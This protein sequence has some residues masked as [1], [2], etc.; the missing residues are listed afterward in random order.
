MTPPSEQE[1]KCP[2]CGQQVTGFERTCP[3]CGRV[4][5][6]DFTFECPFCGDITLKGSA[7]CTSCH[8]ILTDL[9]KEAEPAEVEK[10]AEELTKAAALADSPDKVQEH[11]LLTS[12]DSTYLPEGVGSRCP[13]CGRVLS[14]AEGG[15][16]SACVAPAQFDAE[17]FMQLLD[18]VQN[19]Q[20]HPATPPPS[21]PVQVQSRLERAFDARLNELPEM[22]PCPKCG[23]LV[24]PSESKCP[25]CMAVLSV[26]QSGA[27][28][29]ESVGKEEPSE[30][31]DASP[32]TSVPSDPTREGAR[33]LESVN[34]IEIPAEPRS[35]SLGLS[36]GVGRTNGSGMSKVNG[37]GRVNGTGFTNGKSMVNGTGVSN[38]LVTEKHV[39]ARDRSRRS[40]WQFLV[41]LIAVAIVIPTFIA[42]VYLR[43]GDG[44]AVDGDF[45][46][47]S[48]AFK[49]SARTQADLSS[50]AIDE[51]SVAVDGRSLSFYVETQGD[52]LSS[53]DAQ[54]FYLLVDSDG[55]ASTGYVAGTLGADYMLQVIGWNGSIESAGLYERID[56]ADHLDWNVW[57]KVDNI[58]AVASGT[59]LEA[60]AELSTGLEDSARCILISKAS[61]G[62]GAVSYEA[63][64]SGGLLIV[65]QAP[66][67]EV[68]DDGI[69]PL[70]ATVT[71]LSLNFSC[72]GSGGRVEVVAPTISGAALA[73]PIEPFSL[74]LGEVHQAFVAIDTSGVANG[75]LVSAEIV[76]SN[77]T[78][79]FGCVEIIG[80]KVSSYAGATTGSI[81]IDGAF[82]DWTGLLVSDSD[83]VPVTNPGVD[84]DQFGNV[85]SSGYSFFYVSVDGQ[86][87]RGTH[88]PAGVSKPSN[89]SGGGGAV[90]RPP[91]M[92]GEDILSI[93]I[94][95]DKLTS[96]GLKYSIGSDEIGADHLIQVC[97]VYGRIVSATEYSYSSGAWAPATGT[98]VT[99]ENDRQRMEIGVSSSSLGGSSNIRY[100]IETTSWA[101]SGDY[102]TPS[103]T[104]LRALT[105]SVTEGIGFNDWPV[106]SNAGSPYATAMSY[107]RKLFYDG[108]NFW[109]F[110]F[111]GKNT[112]HKYSS[113]NGVT[114]TRLGTVFKTT[115]V[116]ETSIWYDSANNTVYAVGDTSTPSRNVMLQRGSVFPAAHNI[117]W[118]ESDSFALVSTY[119]TAGKNAFI[120]RDSNG[121]LWV[122]STNCSE[123]GP[124]KYDL[125]VLRSNSTN[126]VSGWSF[127]GNMLSGSSN[128]ANM[129][130]SIVPAGS[131]SV[132]WCVYNHAAD[133]S[134]RRYDGAWQSKK[135][136]YS[137]LTDFTDYGPASVLVDSHGVVHVVYGTG[138]VSGPDPTPTI[139]YVKNNTGSDTYSMAVDLDV[140]IPSDVADY[141]PTISLD[142]STNNLYVFWLRTDTTLVGKTVMGRKCVS[143]SW[144][145]LT[146]S[147][148][149]TFAKRCLTSIY[150][151]SG[152][153]KI[154]WQWTQNTSSYLETRYD[155]LIPEFSDMLPP[156][157]FFMAIIAVYSRRARSR[158]GSAF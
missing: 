12:L 57:T 61:T 29:V 130:A 103:Q 32:A 125:T 98:T 93:Y 91:K 127:S 155:S 115:G 52:V 101:G 49:F 121:Y 94:D 124:S 90:V 44:F 68:A 151:V 100:M 78:S 63:P 8:L 113:D 60:E 14:P 26:V 156:V 71:V 38:G 65:I 40:G 82:A 106:D 64:T 31:V 67:Q 145:N 110:F 46:E 9:H 2:A 54:S 95:S 3:K 37:L 58:A 74:G 36:N 79:S 131:G 41:V 73:T 129:K 81:V 62:N 138:P 133:I 146:L 142:S 15:I 39:V 10:P 33:E 34:I 43:E 153:S 51:W 107:Q 86:I 104:G 85:N 148:D 72:Q 45:G 141:Y 116:N 19:V 17:G 137:A 11:P 55:T 112:V 30:G 13:K 109:S 102:V 20:V 70:D 157:L 89:A 96:T 84:I 118:A 147:S 97:G 18:D 24:G 139:H 126:N 83:V 88:V 77:I 105:S 152:E 108:T 22:S 5:G 158:R 99:A 134:S 149:T 69:V 128:A 111:D 140:F 28:T 7:E 132:V 143:G 21:P 25:K 119:V 6:S 92:T 144:S 123:T 1:L 4:F 66:T 122:V 35:F 47:W 75:E 23:V 53:E 80:E 135:T 76:S 114:W 59:M 50:I 136:L 27:G 87:C 16:C 42:F 117:T 154:C 150:S 120:C 56:S 48:D